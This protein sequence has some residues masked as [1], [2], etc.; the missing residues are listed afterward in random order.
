MERFDIMVFRGFESID[1]LTKIGNY[2]TLIE[3]LKTEMAEAS[4]TSSPLSIAIF[5]IDNFKK[6][7]DSKGH[8]CG[9]QVLVDVASIMNNSIRGTDHVGRYGGEGFMVIFP[10]RK[11]M[12]SVLFN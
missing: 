4:R 2:R 1:R 12:N 3:H 6:V 5:D 11:S 7:N 8:V 9:D 10:R